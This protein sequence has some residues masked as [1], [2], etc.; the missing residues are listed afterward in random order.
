IS[1]KPFLGLWGF[2]QRG[3]RRSAAF[4]E[5]QETY[6]DRVT[7]RPALRVLVA[8]LFMATIDLLN[9]DELPPVLAV[10]VQYV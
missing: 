4:E 2:V 9:A 10:A 3:E 6:T 7:K 8:N 5:E 1:S